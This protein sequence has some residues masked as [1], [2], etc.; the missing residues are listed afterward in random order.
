MKRENDLLE[1]KIAEI[2]TAIE[3][4]LW[5]Q[6]KAKLA[7]ASQQA[8]QLTFYNAIETHRKEIDEG[9]DITKKIDAILKDMLSKRKQI[10]PI[11]K[12]IENMDS[13]ITHLERE[14]LIAKNRNKAKFLRIEKLCQ[15]AEFRRQRAQQKL[16]SLQNK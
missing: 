13:Q 8:R 10:E 2:D 11:N 12:E 15:E 1:R 16:T 14:N 3:K 7:L 9:T 4:V 6:N 5:E